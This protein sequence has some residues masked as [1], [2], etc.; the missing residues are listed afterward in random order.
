MSTRRTGKTTRV[1][2]RIIQEFFIKGK[3]YI[4]ENRNDIAGTNELRVKVQRRLELEHPEAKY[5]ISQDTID[6]IYCNIIEKHNL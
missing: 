5:V 6:G 2:D 3:A 1:I 4:Y